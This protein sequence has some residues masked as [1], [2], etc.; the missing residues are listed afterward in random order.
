MPAHWVVSPFTHI[1]HTVTFHTWLFC[2]KGVIFTIFSLVSPFTQACHLSHI[3]T[4][5]VSLIV[6]AKD[7]NNGFRLIVFIDKMRQKILSYQWLVRRTRCMFWSFLF[8]DWCDLWPQSRRFENGS[9]YLKVTNFGDDNH[10]CCRRQK[11]LLSSKG[12][13]SKIASF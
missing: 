9:F 7:I 2:V 13:I 4:Q 3:S 5:S 12:W 11:S 8:F 1:F 6:L 10:D